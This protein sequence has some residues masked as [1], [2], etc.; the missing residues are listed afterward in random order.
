MKSTRR[1]FCQSVAAAAALSGCGAKLVGDPNGKKVVVLGL[2][3][4]EPKIIQALTRAARR[5]LRS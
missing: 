1:E 2:D 3:G 5:T 4:M